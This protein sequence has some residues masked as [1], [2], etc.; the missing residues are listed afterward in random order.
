MSSAHKKSTYTTVFKALTAIFILSI[1][2]GADADAKGL[3]GSG[4]RKKRTQDVT[5]VATVDSTLTGNTLDAATRF[6]SVSQIETAIKNQPAGER[7][8][9]TLATST[10]WRMQSPSLEIAN[11][12]AL[13]YPAPG[14]LYT[15]EQLQQIAA[16]ARTAGVE[17]VPTLD[18]LIENQPFQRCFGHSI[19]SVEGMRLV[20]AALEDCV[21]TM[22]PERICLGRTTP[23]A[24]ERYRN[25]LNEIAGILGVKFIIFE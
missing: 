25:F 22:H 17:L 2:L 23:D 7:F 12:S 20:R 11:P 5:P 10:T 4:K 8:Y 18:L 15:R 6:L 1:A 9:L 21:N 16:T 3:F 19:F 24:D 14:S 13:I